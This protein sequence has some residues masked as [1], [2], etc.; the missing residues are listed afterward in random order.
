MDTDSDGDGLRSE[1]D[2]TR[3]NQ[4]NLIDTISPS[5]GGFMDAQEP[6]ETEEETEEGE[7]KR[8]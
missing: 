3:R 2:G 5:F 8:A 4:E 7:F 1:G 6:M